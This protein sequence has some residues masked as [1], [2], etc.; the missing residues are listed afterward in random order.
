[1][2]EHCTIFTVMYVEL[3]DFNS[4]VDGK[5]Q[6][7]LRNCCRNLYSA[8]GLTIIDKVREY[9]AIKNPILVT[10]LRLPQSDT[11]G[12]ASKQRLM[13]NSTS[14]R[15]SRQLSRLHNSDDENRLDY[16]FFAG[17]CL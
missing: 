5:V 10:P 15:S 3:D 13:S 12:W 11:T 14:H 16:T 4:I 7:K 6:R 8:L 17:V 1:M 9:T 2:E